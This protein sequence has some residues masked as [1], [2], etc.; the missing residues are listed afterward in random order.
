MT[1]AYVSRNITNA[2]E[3]SI[4]N[5]EQILKKKSYKKDTDE[6]NCTPDGL[7]DNIKCN[8]SDTSE[9]NEQIHT[10][11][12]SNSNKNDNA[13][14]VD[15]ITDSQNNRTAT[16]AYIDPHTVFKYVYK[17][18]ESKKV[19]NKTTSHPK[20]SLR[21]RKRSEYSEISENIKAPLI[22][23]YETLHPQRS[24]EQWE[25]KKYSTNPVKH[26]GLAEINIET[27]HDNQQPNINK[28]E[29]AVEIT[30]DNSSESNE[31]DSKENYK[32]NNVKLETSSEENNAQNSES[33]ENSRENEQYSKNTEKYTDS[34]ENNRNY[35]KSGKEE[36]RSAIGINR[37][38]IKQPTKAFEYKEFDE[39]KYV[40]S[41]NGVDESVENKSEEIDKT[42]RNVRRE[43]EESNGSYEYQRDKKE[44]ES[45]EE[46]PQH[47]DTE[48]YDP[49]KTKIPAKIQDVDLGDYER[50][51]VNRN[52]EIET[53]KDNYEN[54][55]FDPSIDVILPST[56]DH[57]LKKSDKINYL[58]KENADFSSAES[59]DDKEPT[60]INDG[61]VKPVVELNSEV[62]NAE[63]SEENS[64]ED[65]NAKLENESLETLTGLKEKDINEKSYDLQ[66]KNV[67]QTD[68]D[69]KQ[70]YE[71]I[72]LDY[73]HANK[74]QT[75]DSSVEQVETKEQ[76]NDND[77]DEPTTVKPN[78]RYDENLNIKFDDIN[79]KLPDIKLPD[80]ILSHAYENTPLYK[81]NEPNQKKKTSKFY[82]NSHIYDKNKEEQVE[83]PIH[84]R[85]DEEE[86]KPRFYHYSDEVEEEPQNTPI[87]E[88]DDGEPITYNNDYYDGYYKDEK[89][90]ENYKQNHNNDGEEDEDLYEKFVRERFGKRGTSKQRLEKLTDYKADNPHLYQQVKKILKKTKDVNAEAEKSGDPKAGYM[91][92]L[93]Y[94]QQL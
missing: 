35:D 40:K 19:L 49:L 79:I 32:N 37:F 1:D 22:V 57:K 44:R 76:I 58:P 50:I 9:L 45:S 67:S 18:N 77:S 73:N 78:Q 68:S 61:E 29:P 25:P 38:D 62:N 84:Y 74:E 15:D 11:S 43:K 33:I 21:R 3:T 36:L 60:H 47:K 6:E 81:V 31:S 26:S 13:T 91:W 70:Q 34:Q 65:I 85:N 59:R 71:R 46:E 54:T 75:K 23:N 28:Q 24:V 94:G 80:D 90:K 88:E 2:T 12:S 66:E 30:P 52:G 83:K 4:T 53:A 39:P 86:E 48:R 42:N 55:A 41:Q 63:S 72:P 20:N 82:P 56:P 27:L 93:E 14:V 17:K 10:N 87:K 69:V 8:C 16:S 5:Q 92:T 7:A 64:N 51:Q 89:K